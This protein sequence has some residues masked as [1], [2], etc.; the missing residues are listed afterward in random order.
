MIRKTTALLVMGWSILGTA[1]CDTLTLADVQAAAQEA[2]PGLLAAEQ[3]RLASE[4]DFLAA[5]GGFDTQLKIQNRWSATGL[6]ENQNY[7]IS[8]EQPTSLWGTTFFGGWRRGTGDYP[9]YEGKSITADDGEMR[10][11]INVPLWRDRSIDRR[12]ASLKQAELSRLIAGHD[13][14]L[15]QL[16]IRRQA[17]HRYWD[18][19]LA[20][21]R[22]VIAE[23]LLKIAE[24]RD[25]GIRDRVAAG[26]IPEFEAVDNQRA[27]VERRERRVAAQR[28]LEQAAIQLSL[29]WRD[30]HG[31]PQLPVR[32]QLPTQFPERLPQPTLPLDQAVQTALSNR[33]ELKRIGLQSKQMAT[34]L[35]LQENQRAPGINVSVMGAQD[36]GTSKSGLNRD[37]LY[38]G[39]NVDIP[40]QRRVAT[41]RAQAAGAQLQRIKWDGDLLQNRIVAEIQDVLSA[42]SAASQRTD[43]AQQ[44]YD[45]AQ[46]LEEGERTRF[47]V[48]ASTLLFVNLREMAS[49]DA[50]LAAATA[51]GSLFKAYADYQAVLAIPTH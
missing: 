25:T 39:L 28:L 36:F 47:E 24:Q 12:R 19:V 4:G 30:A 51:T 20:G 9:V 10:L 38:V 18:W 22:L 41:G 45:V 23:A 21:Q 50:A 3:K 29:Y 34:E 2:F 43:L 16:D 6:Y 46:Q 11:G 42:L 1:Q 31:E 15:A 13:Y 33:P 26:D 40:L 14:D 44:Q 5:E 7:D 48:G 27:I 49:G 32:T 35:A 17:A 8:L 37:E